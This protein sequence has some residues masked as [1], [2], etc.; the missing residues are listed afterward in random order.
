MRKLFKIVV[1][2]ASFGACINARSYPKVHID[3]LIDFTLKDSSA[4]ANEVLLMNKLLS[5]PQFWSAIKEANFFCPNQRVYHAK[6]KRKSEYP[7]LKK[8][9]HNYSSAEIHDLL[10]YGQDEIGEEKDGIINLKLK[11]KDYPKNKNGS[12]THGSTNSGS[13]I[14]SSDR[15]TRIH[16]KIKGKYAAHLLHE[17][18]H[19]LGFKHKSN[20]PSKNKIKC[21]G[22]DVP[23]RIQKIAEGIINKKV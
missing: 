21:G 8:D 9:K 19:V 20:L 3:T 7:R 1:L 4:L 5:N 23:L 22:I 2:I 14:I 10:W 15:A 17:Y 18:M 16:S 6:R 13:L 12:Q 11:A